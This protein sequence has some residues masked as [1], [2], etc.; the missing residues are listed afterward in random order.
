MCEHDDV[1]KRCE[2]WYWIA[3]NSPVPKTAAAVVTFTTRPREADDAALAKER[4]A[5]RCAVREATRAN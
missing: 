3:A 2:H 5:T 4:E 1:W